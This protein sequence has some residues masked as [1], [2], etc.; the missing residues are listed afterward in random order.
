MIGNE[1]TSPGGS[2]MMRALFPSL[3]KTTVDKLRI[4]YQARIV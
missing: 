4:T 2:A 1:N 3:D